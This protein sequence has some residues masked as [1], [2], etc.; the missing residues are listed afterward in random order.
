MAYDLNGA[1]EA[2][3]PLSEINDYL[4]KKYNYDLAGARKNNVSESDIVDYL[5]SK[6]KPTKN[7]DDQSDLGAGFKTAFKQIPQLGY[8][9]IAGA[10]AVAE[11]ALGEGGVSTGVKEYGLKKYQESS[12]DIDKYQ[13]DVYDFNV[14]L[15]KAKAGDIGAMADWLQYGLGYG[16]GQ[17]IQAAVTGGVGSV[18]GKAALSSATKSVLAQTV[19]KQATKIAAAELGAGATAEAIAKTAAT[20]VVRN[21]AAR[22]VASSI[23]AGMALGAQN[24]GMEG[25]EIFGDLTASAAKEGRVLDGDEIARAFGATIGAAGVETA[26]DMLGLG[27]LTGKIKIGGTGGLAS[28]AAIGG[29]VGAGTEFGTEYLQTGIE[30]Y[31]KGE[32]VFTDQAHRERLAAGALG[33]VG[34]GGIGSIGGAL[35]SSKQRDVGTSDVMGS[36]SVDMAIDNAVKAADLDLK[37]SLV[38][39]LASDID[40]YN[41]ASLRSPAL[42]PSES[43][44]LAA[45]KGAMDRVGSLDLSQPATIAAPASEVVAAGD[46]AA[47][48]VEAAGGVAT[49]AQAAML[50]RAFPGQKMYDQ[51]V[52]SS[53][54]APTVGNQSPIIT[55]TGRAPR[56]TVRFDNPMAAENAEG[57]N[58][59][60]A[61]RQQAAPATVANEEQTATAAPTVN[62]GNVIE[63]LQTA[64]AL[65][66]AEQRV[67]LN[68]AR[69]NLS[70]EDF[71]LLET[72]AQGR[73]NLSAEQKIRLNALE[74]NTVFQQNQETT[75]SQENT[76]KLSTDR[77]QSTDQATEL[78]K[79]EVI[80][81]PTPMG[82]GYRLV[83]QQNINGRQMYIYADRSVTPSVTPDNTQSAM[84]EMGTSVP[85]MGTT[86]AAGTVSPKSG[87]AT[88]EA[89]VSNNDQVGSTGTVSSEGKTYN[90]NVVDSGVAPGVSG[91]IQQ[92]ARLFGKKVVFFTSDLA[93]DGFVQPGK[94]SAIYINANSK[95]SPLAV[96]GHELMHLLK[97]DNPIAYKAVAAVVGRNLKGDAASKFR[98]YYN[99][100]GP[101]QNSELT[102]AELEEMVADL[103]GNE[104]TQE[105]FLSDVFNEIGQMAPEGQARSIILRLAA[106]INKA[107]K[108]ALNVI[109][110]LHVSQ[111]FE[112]DQ[113]VNNLEEIR[114]AL[115]SALKTYAVQQKESAAKMA[116][117]FTR[118]ETK[119]Q[120]SPTRDTLTSQGAENATEND[121]G[122]ISSVQQNPGQNRPGS[123]GYGRNQ[124]DSV[125]SF[126]ESSDR[127]GSVRVQGV[128]YS[129][130]QLSQVD[131]NYYGSN[132]SRNN[133]AEAGRVRAARDSRLGQRGYF[134][135][136]TGN[137]IKPEEGVGSVPH[138]AYLNNLYDTATGVITARDAND[139]ETAVIDAGFDGYIN[140]SA[141]MAVV[142]GNKQVPVIPSDGTAEVVPN[143]KEASVRGEL[144]KLKTL[145]SGELTRE[146]WGQVLKAARP[147]LHAKIEPSGAFNGDEKVYKD[148]LVKFSKSRTLDTA[149]K[150]DTSRTGVV[151]SSKPGRNFSVGDKTAQI[152]KYP[153]AKDLEFVTSRLHARIRDIL[154]GTNAVQFLSDFAGIKASSL[155]SFSEIRGLWMGEREDTFLIRAKGEDGKDLSFDASRIISNLLG[156]AF[157]QEGAITYAPS[158]GSKD[159]IPSVYIGKPDGSKL[160]AAEIDDALMEAHKAGFAGASA[161]FN[162]N[163]IKIMFF[164]DESSGLSSD[165]QLNEFKQRVESIQNATG[166][167]GLKTYNTLSELDSANDY[168]KQI[169]GRALSGEGGELG[170]GRSAAGSSD[171][172]RG[173]VDNLLAPYVSA[174]KTEGFEFSIRDWQRVFDATDEQAKYLKAKVEELDNINKHGVVKKLRQTVSIANVK[175]VGSKAV[176]MLKTT[177]KNAVDQLEALDE[178]FASASNPV[179]STENWLRMEA[180]AY[181]TNDVPMAPNRFISMYNSDGIYEQLKTL[182]PGQ[183]SDADHGAEMGQEFRRLYEAG[184]VP[185]ETTAKLMLWSFL[186]RGVSPYVQESGFLDLVNKIDPFIPKVLDGTFSQ[187]DADAWNK[188]VSQSIKKGTGQPGAGTTHNANA[189]GSS[190][191]AGMA[192]PVADGRTKLQYLHDLFSDPTKNGRDIRREFIK[193]SEGVGIDNK[194]ISFTLLVV[195]HDDVAVL[196]RVQINNTFNDGRLGES[197][198]LYDGVT[199]YGYKNDKDETVWIGAGSEAQ[200]EAKS[201]SKDGEVV[202]AIL[203]GSGLANLTTGARGLMLYEP[204][205][206]ALDM[207]LPE[208]YSRLKK[209]GLRGKDTRPSVGRWHWESWVASSGQEASHKTLEALLNEVKGQDKP[210]ADVSAKEGEYGSYAYG[211]E[212]AIDDQGNTYKLYHDTNG[213]AYKF[214]LT[215]Y[216]ELMKSIKKKGGDAV[217]PSKFGVSTNADGSQRTEPWF[218][219]PRVNQEKLNNLIR[220]TGTAAAGIEAQQA[221]I[222]DQS[223]NKPESN[224]KLSKPRF[225]SQLERTIEQVPVRLQT[226]PAAQWKAWLSANA[227]KYGIKKEEIEWSGINDYLALRGKDKVTSAEIGEFL[228]LNN[229]RVTESIKGDQGKYWNSIYDSLEKTGEYKYFMFDDDGSFV[230]Q[231][232]DR[233]DGITDIADA[234]DYILKR[235]SDTDT[236][237]GE[238]TLPGGRNYRELMLTLPRTDGVEYDVPS[239]HQYGDYESDVNRLAHVRYNERT[240]ADGKKVLFVEEIQ[241][242]WA[243]AGRKQGFGKQL[244]SGWEL[245]EQEPG[246]FLLKQTGRQTTFASGNIETVQKNGEKFGAFKDGVPAAP[247]ISN[248]KDWVALAIK[249]VML[250]AA[251]DGF[252]KVAFINGQQSADRYDLSQKI[253]KVEYT[254]GGALYAWDKEDN[255]ILR[256]K[257]PESAVEDYIGKDLAVKLLASEKGKYNSRSLTGAELEVGGEGMKS[258]YDRIV[259]QV[260]GDVLKKLGGGNV[261]SVDAGD[262]SVVEKIE[263]TA[264]IRD[265]PFGKERAKLTEKLHALETGYKSM[266]QPGFTVTPEMREKLKGDGLPL[267]SKSRQTETP[268]FKQWFKDS[269]VV[270][271]T[272][273]PLM[274]YHGT[275]NAEVNDN[276]ITIFASTKNIAG[277]FTPDADLANSYT[278]VHSAD[279]DEIGESGQ[280]IYPVY[281][282]IANPLRIDFDIREESR[283]NHLLIKLSKKLGVDIDQY[284]STPYYQY[285]WEVI[286]DP[287]FVEAITKAGYDGIIAPE[288]GAIT[289]AALHPTQ[290]KSAIGNNGQFNPANPD[291]TKSNRRQ[292]VAD[293]IAGHQFKQDI[294]NQAKYKLADII[295]PGNGFNWFHKTVG[296]QFHKAKVNQLF[297]KVFDLGQQFLDDVTLFAT[298]AEDKA[299]DIFPR[300][301]LSKSLLKTGLSKADNQLIGRALAEGTLEN[302]P[303]PHDGVIWSDDQLRTKYGM[304]DKQIGYYHQARAAIN[305]SLDDLSKSEMATHMRIAMKVDITPLIRAD[306]SLADV[307]DMLVQA[308][309]SGIATTTNTDATK[310]LQKTKTQI[311]GIYSKATN[312]KNHGYAPLSRFG[313]WFVSAKDK[314]GK[315]VFFEMTDTKSEASMIA[316]NLEGDFGS[317]VVD[318][319]KQEGHTL[320]NGIT[321][322]S[323][324]LFAE[325]AAISNEA[326]VQEYLQLAVATRSSLKRLIN[327][328]GTAGYSLDATRTLASFL[329]SN[330]R[331]SSSALNMSDMKQSALAIDNDADAHDE[332]VKLV[333]Y[334]QNP[335]EEA[336][337]LRGFL[338]FQYLGGSIA[339]GIVNLTQPIMMT[340]P[341]LSQ[342]GAGKA[343]AAMKTGTVAAT[344]FLRG[345]RVGDPILQAAMEKAKAEGLIDPQEIYQLMAASQSGAGSFMSYKLMRLWGINF[346]VTELMNRAVTFAAAFKIGQTLSKEDLQKA[347]ATD[348]YSFAQNTIYET[349][350]LYN[351][352]NRPDW[353]RGAVGGTVFTFKQYSI[354]Y[355]EFMT[356]LYKNDKKAFGIALAILIMAAGLQGLPGADD[357]DD[358]IDTAGNWMGYATNTKKWKRELLE[359]V[360]GEDMAAF[361]L[362]GVSTLPGMPIDVQARLGLGNIIPGT[363]LMNP[364]KKD[365][366]REV[367]EVFGVAGGM[368]MSAMDTTEALAKGDVRRAALSILPGAIRNLIQAQEMASTGEYRD[369]RGRLV[370]KVSSGDVLAKAIGFQPAEIAAGNRKMREVQSDIDIVKTKQEEVNGKYARAIV[371]KDQEAMSEV[372]EE[373]RDWNQK[374]PDLRIKFN[375]SAIQQRV[376]QARLTKEAR[377]I[378][379]APQQMRQQ[380][381]SAVLD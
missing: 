116:M 14:A 328:K 17:V 244:A 85:D 362:H 347:G 209:D 359:S 13:K 354:S 41:A 269:K 46:N 190:F 164:E 203:P 273:K 361:A 117:E 311:N 138:T 219:D 43:L 302:G 374:N 31:G 105:S 292:S 135:I 180:I 191:M 169:T 377:F 322:D 106:T 21:A 250:L 276:G 148:Q 160:T 154:S 230:D 128:H 91:A 84:P 47:R 66:S 247:F 28:R 235:T 320:F 337:K 170:M 168:W 280:Q 231:F 127:P 260:V 182:S 339:S 6:E 268:E 200:E 207:K 270:D 63:A 155:K 82:E 80:Y 103:M 100:E 318:K 151:V 206:N 326:L 348:A 22:N 145:P 26:V 363:G 214:T 338:F 101:N 205:E 356:R 224:V 97:R 254:E 37:T 325:Y 193:I 88:L 19:E 181:G 146:R 279:Y 367:A 83:G 4:G 358:V 309:D 275:S 171:L 369:A 349:Q 257:I 287:M 10:G 65:Q 108:A 54:Q 226:Q 198:N 23:G 294:I 95:M 256:K 147:D 300:F 371:D 177:D 98:D 299:A 249:R 68:A 69:Q 64:P 321:L 351:K 272:G 308:L 153:K 38:P 285:A 225:Y 121:T 165:E 76:A 366:G 288:N 353:A 75:N 157:I 284:F 291:I 20:D 317:V 132:V 61:D 194:V 195:G 152:V 196:D 113:M 204:I 118:E 53:E 59:W 125:P 199:R 186:S 212:Y 112:T 67:T 176:L 33:A 73:F 94:D 216:N 77:E 215:Q 237:F 316:K 5:L 70:A 44:E 238:Y 261:E 340:Y 92:F 107:I 267:F 192:Q 202:T 87:I 228:N 51:V 307:R 166:L 139:F 124:N 370:Q 189:F 32:D 136:N 282:S 240:D 333:E 93:A 58:R 344:H 271:Q 368:A 298:R 266:A 381:R 140:R 187:K 324:E 158:Y 227:A 184:K 281:L 329:T 18:A 183:V 156:F 210:F 263:L 345:K 72:A 42:N 60:N 303:N 357:L 355:L 265:L 173:T 278:E 178:V 55:D 104:F 7:L 119:V 218:K 232:G 78:P 297:K 49:P 143:S 11:S 167:S 24:V 197:Y 90:F 56:E 142:L 30:Q 27:A 243:Q 234:A 319:M 217:V 342:F 372:R 149:V 255:E 81:S 163:G 211:T 222:G 375:M 233:V 373:I 315:A 229:V 39:E 15:D 161:G 185:P 376:K 312:L 239:A 379:S 115:K 350:G 36:P 221:A 110:G 304:N 102:D 137:G 277:W 35:S 286:N 126:G 2:G 188:V 223:S 175:D 296:T 8:G 327:R 335:G 295:A 1:L 71:Q 259:P 74:N 242:D 360:L 25:G 334:L 330:A 283:N 12:E 313:K 293:A 50:D 332:A 29:T 179:K 141:G 201:K 96:F 380:V 40:A 305:Q 172:F 123:V 364:A 246:F 62:V 57:W 264:K 213:T 133:G 34:G 336:A 120:L 111:G 289:Y 89:T 131:G 122:R 306:L 251:Q 274:V 314:N 365:K 258:F 162:G 52:G 208:I 99:A 45:A 16:A 352:G 159:G 241:S 378:K 150:N 134:Y 114:A 245:K 9:L 86:S 144:S 236:R 48:E 331:K 253:D 301:G 3:V 341:Y 310:M 262:A 174:I 346:G 109:K 252:D 130:D 343:G 79:A 220:E 129:K 248:T 290:I 323:I